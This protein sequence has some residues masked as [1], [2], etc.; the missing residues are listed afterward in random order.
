[1]CALTIHSLFP[2]MAT[3]SPALSVSP[4]AMFAHVVCDAVDCGHAFAMQYLE[5]N[6]MIELVG[7]P[8]CSCERC[9]CSVTVVNATSDSERPNW[10]VPVVPTAAE[11][12][13]D[14]AMK[15]LA[16]QRLTRLIES[17]DVQAHISCGFPLPEIIPLPDRCGADTYCHLISI[18][19]A[20]RS[21]CPEADAMPMPTFTPDCFGPDDDDVPITVLM[22]ELGPDD[23]EVLL[24]MFGPDADEVPTNVLAE[25]MAGDH[26]LPL[27]A[28]AGDDLP[29]NALA[30]PSHRGTSAAGGSGEMPMFVGGSDATDTD[31]AVKDTLL[32]CTSIQCTNRCF[33][34]NVASKVYLCDVCL[35]KMETIDGL[36]GLMCASIEGDAPRTPKRR[37]RGHFFF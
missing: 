17:F 36:L 14:A 37:R 13:R 26:E 11:E 28:M 22:R 6:S 19:D 31:G 10:R 8:E 5:L 7:A 29:L 23:D 9:G 15:L 32:V 20:L 24:L 30:K 4:V 12:G 16:E 35:S 25:T 2:G 3:A 1:M 21:Y 27:E 33:A 34:G 18:D